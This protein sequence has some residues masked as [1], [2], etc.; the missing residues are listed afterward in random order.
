MGAKGQR[1]HSEHP[2]A[3]RPASSRF[4]VVLRRLLRFTFLLAVAAGVVLTFVR[5]T[6]RPALEGAAGAGATWPPLTERPVRSPWVEPVDRACP[7]GY[8]VKAKLSSGIYHLPGMLNYERTI[9]DRC[10]ES[11]AAA[12]ADG[13]RPAKR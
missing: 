1:L 2:T 3:R 10:Y 9:P 11:A 7:D 6:R 5:R 12:A 8:P 4:K 13:L